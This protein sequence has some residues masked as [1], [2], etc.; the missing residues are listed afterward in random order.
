MRYLAHIAYRG[1]AFRGWQVQ[2]R[3]STVQ[4]TL[5][6]ALSTILHHK[7]EIV[8]CGRTDTGVHASNYYF[9]FDY[10][11]EFPPAFR[12]RLNKYL[13]EDI[14]IYS[15]HPI[16]D[17]AHARYDAVARAYQYHLSLRKV[18]LAKDTVWH[19][20]FPMKLQ[21]EQLNTTARIF[22]EFDE[23]FPFCKSKSDVRTYRCDLERSEWIRLD[24]FR[25]VYHVRADRFLRGM[26][27]LL[28]GACLNVARG[29][30]TNAEIETA[31]RQQ[32]RLRKDWSVPAAGLRLAEVIY[33]EAIFRG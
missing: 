17:D 3:Q 13:P 1:S 31:L 5:E 12:R 22:G 18:P 27:R 9:H 7:I 30:L 15:V 21:P 23:F 33:P 29:E 6:D 28:V 8:G 14:A 11:T 2:P 25:L 32:V 20:P 24:E 26:V 16:Q 19:F 4:G 10:P